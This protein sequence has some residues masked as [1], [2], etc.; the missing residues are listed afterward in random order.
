[1][2]MT[3]P[4]A[5]NHPDPAAPPVDKLQMYTP[6]YT[7]INRHGPVHRE[8]QRA[9]P[10][11]WIDAMHKAEDNPSLTALRQMSTFGALSNSFIER[12]LHCGQ[13]RWLQ[14]GERLFRKGEH[15]DC[16]YVV[17][18]GH[19]TIYDENNKRRQVFRTTEIGESL[20]FAAM[21][22]LRP[23]LFSGE[24][25]DDCT[26]LRLSSSDF[27]SL[28][29]TDHQQFAILFMNLSRDMSRLLRFSTEGA[30]QPP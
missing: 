26:L 1:M 22:A 28:Y 25:R 5:L 11:K 30:K 21:I 12:L 15:T 27:A 7:G 4:T 9:R 18:S 20:G 8:A 10:E 23:L 16:F 17:L 2:T 3:T 14:K 6:L 19:I 29:D 24:A 13:L